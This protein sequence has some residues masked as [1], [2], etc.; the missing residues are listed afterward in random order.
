[1]TNI[2]SNMPFPSYEFKEY[3]KRITDKD[4]VR[5]RVNSA[6]EEAAAL[7]KRRAPRASELDLEE[8]V[9]APGAEE[10]G[11]LTEQEELYNQA[12]EL[13]ISAKPSWGAARL[14]REIEKAS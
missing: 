9:V 5:V 10:D 7:G 6:D 11:E 3:P 2:F 13:G 1:M 4:G 14:R 8:E 12:I